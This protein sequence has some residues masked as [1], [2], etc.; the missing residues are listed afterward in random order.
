MSDTV[1]TADK[2][3]KIR[4]DFEKQFPARDH[5]RDN[6]IFAHWFSLHYGFKVVPRCL[7]D[8]VI[9][10]SPNVYAAITGMPYA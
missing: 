1:L 9:A 4:D 7:P 3:R 8:D 6:A 5:I 2:L 10:V